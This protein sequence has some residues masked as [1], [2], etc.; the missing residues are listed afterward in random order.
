MKMKCLDNGDSLEN[1]LKTEGSLEKP[2]KMESSCEKSL[3]M[4][5]ALRS[6]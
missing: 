3:K 2:L 1:P 6:P 5:V 4:K